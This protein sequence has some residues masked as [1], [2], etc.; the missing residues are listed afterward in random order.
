MGAFVQNGNA[1]GATAVLGTTDAN[2]LQIDTN[3]ISRATVTSTGA[4]TVGPPTSGTALTVTGVAST[5]A[6]SVTASGTGSAV[7]ATNNGSGTTVNVTNNGA[8][9]AAAFAS[10]TSAGLGTETVLISQ[11][12]SDTALNVLGASGDAINASNTA[13]APTIAASNAEPTPGFGPLLGITLQCTAS[14]TDGTPIASF[15][16][17]AGPGDGIII[18]CGVNVVGPVVDMISFYRPDNTKVGSV[19]QN[20]STTVSYNTSSD[21]RIKDTPRPTTA[22]LAA[23]LKLHIH[24]FTYQRDPSK[25]VHHGVIAQ[26]V[27]PIFPTAVHVPEFYPST[28]VPAP[29]VAATYE[30][31]TFEPGVFY[32]ESAEKSAWVAAETER[33]ARWVATEK[34]RQTAWET[35]EATRK[36]G[37]PQQEATR[38]T[39]W[40]AREAAREASYDDPFQHPMGVDYSRFV[41]PA[42][43]AIQ[44]L[45]AQVDALKAEVAA[46]R[47]R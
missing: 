31:T 39:E 38:K 32:G 35:A 13:S 42:L 27:L 8:G 24:D 28:F 18:Q 26:E 41:A 47:A 1:F 36:A 29:F 2:T 5:L 44:E 43:R 10:N 3:N 45:S 16:N 33:K 23:V 9:K 37:W 21:A 15:T 30:P 46:L 40:A 17:T 22:G 25:T 20:T 12:G 14:T 6:L 4:M 19:T 7:T 34:A 11:S